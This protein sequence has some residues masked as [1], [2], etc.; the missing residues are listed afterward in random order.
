MVWIVSGHNDENLIRA[1]GATQDEAW[2][3]AAEQA[4]LW[5]CWGGTSRPSNRE[6]EASSPQG[7]VS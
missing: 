6:E 2:A 3:G 1:E 4:G 7:T 5:G